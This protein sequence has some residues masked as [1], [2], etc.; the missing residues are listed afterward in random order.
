MSFQQKYEK[1]F[2]KK[3]NFLCVGLDPDMDKIPSQFQKNK[4]PILSFNRWII[5]QTLDYAIAYKPNL[6]FYESCGEKGWEALEETCK[7]LGDAEIPVILDAKRG[8]IGNTA[9]QYAKGIFD[10]LEGD[11]ATLAPYMGWDSIAPFAEYTHKVSFIL[12]LT[13]NPS[14]N[15]FEL[16]K[17]EN[18]KTLYETVLN[19][20]ENWRQNF[21][22]LGLVVGATQKEEIKKL[23]E[24]IAPSTPLLVPGVGAQGGDMEAVIQNLYR[25]NILLINVGRAVLYNADPKQAARNFAETMQKILNGKN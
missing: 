3:Q 21:P 17:M 1:N 13:S 23:K 19:T 8:D 2:E 9:R 24:I 18:G 15:D 7:T 20:V 10:I 4:N 6:A 11:A 12:G 22:N 16:K 25:E 14:A 5:E